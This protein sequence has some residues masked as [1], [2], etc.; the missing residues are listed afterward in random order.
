MKVL[1]V[2]SGGREHALVWKMAQSPLVDALY[3][4]PGN[5]GMAA[6]A[7]CVKIGAEDIERLVS[8]ARG[9]GIGLTVVGPEVPLVMGIVDRFQEAGLRIFGPNR[10]AAQLE[11][12]KVFAKGLLRQAR[13][14]TAEFRVFDDPTTAHD[15][16]DSQGEPIVVKADGL[17]AGKGALVC[18]SIDE[19]HE[20]VED[21]MVKKLFG[22][23]L[24]DSVRIQYGGS[25]SADN[26][27]E[28]IACG[29]VDGAL[30]GG[31]SLKAE[32]FTAI[33]KSCL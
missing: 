24:A 18:K 16:L 5:A 26:I 9:E 8:F 11:G 12:S 4:A 13:I 10:E 2:G 1:V 33:V 31:A 7:Q 15:Y 19:A 20:A 6:Q 22:E 3:A 28:L 17:A 30:V 32:S 29:D 27:K 25:V 21:V 23:D 14:P